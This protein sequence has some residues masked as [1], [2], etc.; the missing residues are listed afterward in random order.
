MDRGHSQVGGTVDYSTAEEVE[1]GGSM[2]VIK[3]ELHSANTGK[4]TELGRMAIANVGG[5]NT[6]GDYRVHVCRRG[7]Q[8]ITKPVRTGTVK[9]FPRLS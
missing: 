2:L 6:R 7:S 8:D 5:T 1:V 3:V 4:V 9:G